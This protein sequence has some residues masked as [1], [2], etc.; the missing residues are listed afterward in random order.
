MVGTLLAACSSSNRV[1]G[2]VPSWANPSPRS[3][4]HGPGRIRRVWKGL[5][6]TREGRSSPTANRLKSN[7]T[8][9]PTRLG[10]CNKHFRFDRHVLALDITGVFQALAKSAQLIR[11]RIDA[12]EREGAA[13]F[14]MG[15][16]LHPLESLADIVSGQLCGLLLARRVRQSCGLASYRSSS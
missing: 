9:D 12:R 16:W 1:E 4:R 8:V 15:S 7:C 14:K 13:A 2:V 10:D 6:R 11:H 3:I 5:T